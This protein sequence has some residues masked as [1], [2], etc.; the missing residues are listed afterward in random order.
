MRKRLLLAFALIAYVQSIY[1]A[2]V[3][4]TLTSGYNADVV[5]NG[6]G[7]GL[8][9]TTSDVDGVSYAFV[10]QGWQ[11]TASSTPLAWGLPASGVVNSTVAATPGLYFNLAS[12]SSNNSVRIPTNGTSATMVFSNNVAAKNIFL[13]M[14]SGSGTSYFTGQINFTDGTNQPIST[15]TIIP[16]W[17]GSTAQPVALLGF[18]RINRSS[19]AL[20]ANTSD[21]RL[22]QITIAVLPANQ[23]K[24]VASVQINKDNTS[25]STSVINVFAASAEI[26]TTN[27]AGVSQLTA[28]LYFCQGSNQVKV[29]VKNYGNNVINNLQVQ[30]QLNGVAQTP[31]SL[32]LP[33]DTAG[34]TGL[35]EREVTL[36][37]YTFTGA[38]VTFKS[39]TTL[40]NGGSDG[41]VANDTLG[42]TLQASLSGTYTINSALPTG[43]SNFASFTALSNTLMTYGMCGPVVVNV[44]SG[45]GPYNEIF[46][47]GNV[48][49]SSATNTLRINGGGATVQFTNT[50][51]QRQLLTLSGTQYTRIDSLT[52]KALA[53][54]YGWGALLTSN[55]VFDS[56]TRC[57]FDLT[58]ITSTLSAN[59]SGIAMSGSNTSSITSGTNATNCFIFGN[60][61]KGTTGSGGPYYTLTMTGVNNNN[62]IRG[63]KVENFYLYGIYI[64][65]AGLNNIIENNEVQRAT[66]TTTST[67]YG[68]YLGSSTVGGIV[69]NNRIHS[70]YGGTVANTNSVY[71]IYNTGYGGTSTS[72]A[73]IYNNVIYNINQGGFIYGVYHISSAQYCMYYHNTID[74]SKIQTGTSANYGIYLTGTNT[75][76]EAKNNIISIT[77]G[78][79]GTKYGF[80]YSTA[81]SISSALKNNIY[82][83]STQTG[84]QNY[85]YYTAAYAT[86][87]AFQTAYPAFE[88]GSPAVD[89]QFV[90]PNA[91]NFTPANTALV[92]AGVNLTASVASDINGTLRNNPP[93]IGAFE[94]VTGANNASL[95]ALI[96]PT[97]NFCPGSQAVKV[98]VKNSGANA[99]TSVQINWK[100]NGVTQTPYAW[101]GTLVPATSATGANT[102][103][104]V[105]GTGTFPAGAN[106]LVVWTTV[107]NGTTDSDPT[108]DTLNA[109]VTPANFTISSTADTICASGTATMQL[110]PATGY[111]ANALQWQ[112]SADNGATWND[113]T[114]ANTTSYTATG[115]AASRC[116]RVKIITGG[117][118]C[119]SP[120]KCIRLDTVAILSTTPAARCGTGTVSLSATARPGNTIKWYAASTGGTAL[121]TGGTFVTPS[122][123]TTTTYYVEAA[124]GA[125]ASGCV[126]ATRTPVIATVNAAPAVN[127]GNDTF[128]CPSATINLNATTT[129]ATYLWSTGATTATIAVTTTGTYHVAVTGTNSCVKRDTIVISAGTNPTNP[130][131]ATANLCQGSNI[132]LNAGNAGST[133]IWNGGAT[134]QT[135]NVTAAGTYS[136]TIKNTQGCSITTP[137]T[138]VTTI[139]APVVNLGNDTSIC[140]TAS[141]TLNA[142]NAGASYAWN[143]GATTP[144]ITVNAAGSY[145]VVVTGSNTCVKRDTIIVTLKPTPTNVLPAALDLCQG[146]STTLN[147]ANTGA[148]YLW[149]TGATTQ[150]IN[151][152]SGG[153]Y[154]VTITNAIG[155]SRTT[156]GTTVTMRALPVVNLGPDTI[157]CNHATYVLDAGNAG[158]SYSW[159][160]GAATQTINPIA[161]GTYSVEVTNSYSCKGRDTA[162]VSFFDDP[163]ID[164]FNF[165][166]MFNQQLGMIQF[167]PL[168]PQFVTNYSWDFGDGSAPSTQANPSHVY[169]TSGLYNVTLT[170][171]NHCGTMDTSLVIEVD[172]LATSVKKV[173]PEL[174]NIKLYPNP[175]QQGTL[176]IE[177]AATGVK[178]ENIQL[179]NM[180]GQ[181]MLQVNADGQTKQ[182]ITTNDLAAGTYI[183]H[184]HTNKGM[185]VRK[186]QVIR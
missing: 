10:A 133:Y 54:D 147:A 66:K 163:T 108:N 128:L 2:Y 43:G 1:A 142:T 92:G 61:I 90:A 137:G 174:A 63:N 40:P 131:P 171:S 9:T 48:P 36:G 177:N 102:D 78:T 136:V 50:A 106:S 27:D 111:A 34:G 139:P 26:V 146:S 4:F 25:S 138:V 170:A 94:V 96:T 180:L 38:A 99:I 165:I 141:L 19:D 29:K 79:L 46:S 73:Q 60:Y 88:P 155:C 104:V 17:F 5:V 135:L 176:T 160:T 183:V 101:T 57:T 150:S 30:W 72:P 6:V 172:L 173:N 44:V 126:T 7:T 113:I 112:V 21:P 167:Q 41:F 18:G 80:Y 129:G 125:T 69:R 186:I 121:G 24:L 45:S 56:I 86:Q 70:P 67:F 178:M 77:G 122:I 84:T 149:N 58:A 184:I 127:L 33:L 158:A 3:P 107:P 154:S 130:L 65:G 32:T 55:C 181:V 35:N 16:D 82:V 51:T 62:I 64:T 132:T 117:T 120:V 89:P 95:P 42:A 93:T 74:I 91:G 153:T 143:T 100:I 98:V 159:N 76:S 97:G 110:S 118:N 14:T 49:G 11:Q 119:F 12:Y 47:L 157:V 59:S 168:N 123:A 105:I 31:Y 166:P 185:V 39:W 134:T 151:V 152:N 114:A 68:I 85:G 87:S 144:T 182:F 140:A 103:T 23:S 13:L 81:A 71:A 148:T 124:I 20:E 115:L 116:Y 162:L 28:P 109:T 145:R 22:Y 52:F 164:G 156:T 175:V 75:G 53:T 37:A 8:A 15:A 179:I 83:N 161:T 169:A